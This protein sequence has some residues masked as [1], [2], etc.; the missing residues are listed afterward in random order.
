MKP[1]EEGSKGLDEANTSSSIHSVDIIVI[2]DEPTPPR[3][4]AR[5]IIRDSA[6]QNNSEYCLM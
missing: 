6:R 4:K 5:R 1:S 2:D 3:P